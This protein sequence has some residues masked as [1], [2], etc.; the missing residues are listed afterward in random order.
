MIRAFMSNGVFRSIRRIG[1]QS[2][3]SSSND[4]LRVCIVGTGPAGF[5]TAKYLLKGEE[6][7]HIDLIEAL[8]TPFGLV[9]SGV[10]PDH[11]EVKSVIN[12]FTKVVHD[13]RVCFFGNV[14]VGRDIAVEDLLTAYDA[15]V[16]SYG[17]EVRS[18]LRVP[19]RCLGD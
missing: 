3:S 2:F 8:P 11:P 4:G 13:P 18:M 16:L 7:C 6:Q 19:K 5:Y 17:A 9:R 1:A 10:A 15:V 14:H 12:D